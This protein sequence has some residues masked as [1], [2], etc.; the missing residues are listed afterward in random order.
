[1]LATGYGARA[2]DLASA[3]ELWNRTTGAHVAQIDAPLSVKG[4]HVAFARNVQLCAIS[5]HDRVNFYEPPS[6]EPLKNAFIT[7]GAGESTAVAL[8]A[9]GAIVAFA[10]GGKI[11]VGE[12]KTGFLSTTLEKHTN[13][14]SSLTFTLDGKTLISGGHDCT[15]REWTVPAPK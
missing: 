7:D 4:P 11:H 3:V 10:L 2:H 9:D 14:V 15:V 6:T 8:S 5:S 13:D 1:M 12:A